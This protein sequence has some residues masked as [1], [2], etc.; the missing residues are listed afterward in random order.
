MQLQSYNCATLNCQQEETLLHLFWEC[1]FAV[2][3]WDFICPH[4]TQ[5]LNTLDSISNIKTKLNL[6]FSMEIIVLAAWSIWILRN[7]KIFNNVQPLFKTWK[8]I[9][10]Q[11]LRWLGF[12][13]KKKHEETFKY[14]LQSIT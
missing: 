12:R 6:P 5:G 7:E 11:E 1:P 4:R 13:M 14:W 8:A 9:Y 10:F 3:C 2:K